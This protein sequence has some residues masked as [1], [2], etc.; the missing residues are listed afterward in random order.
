GEPFRGP[1]DSRVQLHSPRS[2]G[3]EDA[4]PAVFR[5]TAARGRR[6]SVGG[7][8]RK[9]DT[10]SCTSGRLCDRRGDLIDQLSGRR[11]DGPSHDRAGESAQGVSARQRGELP[12]PRDAGMGNLATRGERSPDAMTGLG[13]IGRAALIG[14]PFLWLAFLFLAPLL[15]VVKISLAESTIG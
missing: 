8:A 12:W 9:A 13:G 3:V 1:V 7:Q 15:I 14:V 5:H 6:G 4:D 2:G 10:V 11:L